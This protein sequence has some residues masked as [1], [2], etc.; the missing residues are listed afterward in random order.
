[1][2]TQVLGILVG[3]CFIV[4]FGMIVIAGLEQCTGRQSALMAYG[5]LLTLGPIATLSAIGAV[6]EKFPKHPV[7]CVWVFIGFV[8]AG[9]IC[10]RLGKASASAELAQQ[11]EECRL[12]N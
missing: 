6:N 8:V 12:G 4:G 2:S 11:R 9:C 7:M 3:V 5:T 10:W 1:M